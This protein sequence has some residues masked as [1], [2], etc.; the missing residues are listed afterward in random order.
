MYEIAH[1]DLLGRSRQKPPHLR[2]EIVGDR[3]KLHNGVGIK[4]VELQYTVYVHRTGG[5]IIYGGRPSAYDKAT[6]KD[7][8]AVYMPQGQTGSPMTYMAG[9]KQYIVIAVGGPGYPAE[10]LAYRL[11]E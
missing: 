9:G 8:G 6:G 1:P 2:E 10:L 5:E 4:Y 7:A 3:T 11:P